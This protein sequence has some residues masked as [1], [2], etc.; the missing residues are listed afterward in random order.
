MPWEVILKRFMTIPYMRSNSSHSVFSSASCICRRCFY[1]PC[2]SIWDCSK[3]TVRVSIWSRSMASLYV[4]TI[5]SGDDCTEEL[6]TLEVMHNILSFLLLF[7][8]Q[9]LRSTRKQ[10]WGNSQIIVFEMRMLRLVN[11][12]LKS[13]TYF[14]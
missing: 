11:Y 14:T 5:W 2:F 12:Y 7:L 3:F 9:L 6:C 13:W 4:L 1:C 8:L 10:T